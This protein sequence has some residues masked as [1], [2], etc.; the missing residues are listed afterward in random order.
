MGFGPFTPCYILPQELQQFGLPTPDV[1]SDIMNVVELASAL[2]DESWGWEWIVSVHDVHAAHIAPDAKQ[3]SNSTSDATNHAIIDRYGG[4]STS[5]GG[6][7]WNIGEFLLHRSSGEHIN[8]GV[9]W[10]VVGTDR[11]VWTIRV[12]E[13]RHGDWVPGPV[14]VDQSF[15]SGNDVRWTGTFCFDGCHTGGLRSENR[16]VMDSS[17][18]PVTTVLGGDCHL[19]FRVQSNANA[20]G[21]ETCVCLSNEECVS[22]RRRNYEFDVDVIRS[23]R[24]ERDIS[25]TV[26]RSNAGS[27][28]DPL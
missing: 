10:D 6:F 24:G 8:V 22:E 9:H 28:V 4:E 16:R 14:R 18:T 25:P 1:Q 19:Q 20:D 5:D 21:G 17:G 13:T 27:D 3:K 15:E 23:I 26:T 11:G 12:Y 7:R 2:I